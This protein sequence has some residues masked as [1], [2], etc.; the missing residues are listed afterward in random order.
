VKKI[1]PPSDDAVDPHDEKLVGMMVMRREKE[2]AEAE[3]E[4]EER[5]ER[6]R[7]E[8]EKK[9]ELPPY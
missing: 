8:K 1:P 5:E 3:E 2:E 4:E 9:F 6:S 7:W